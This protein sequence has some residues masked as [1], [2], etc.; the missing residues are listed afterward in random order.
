MVRRL[1]EQGMEAVLWVEPYPCRFPYWS[2]LVSAKRQEQC[3]S[4]LPSR[5]EVLHV[6]ALPLEP[7]GLGRWLNRNFLWRQ[8]W[9]RI[10]RFAAEG[11]FVLGIGR[12]CSLALAALR[13]LRPAR[14]FYDAMDNFPEFY[15]GLA[16][17]VMYRN[18]EAVAAEVDFVLASSTFLAE[19]FARRG[20]PVEK[21][22]NAGFPAEL[23]TDCYTARENTR[24]P[25]F[26]YLGCI[27][28]WFDWPLVIR[29]AKAVPWAWLDLVG[30]LAAPLPEKLPINI[31]LHPACSTAEAGEC[32]S[33]FSVGFIPFYNNTLTAGVDPIKYYDYRAAGLPVLSTSFGEMALRDQRDGVYFLD[34]S[35][36]LEATAK[37]ALTHRD[38]PREIERFRREN[39]WNIRFQQSEKLQSLFLSGA[40]RSAA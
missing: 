6:P 29:F 19:K 18:E 26:G 40:K 1:L 10:E 20:L 21:V 39:N 34:R 37:T 35:P 27:G 14:S 2:D 9:R 24:S 22:M 23:S 3:L 38:D 5:V 17:Q 31:N 32:L 30:P 8:T 15:D 16:R 13:R 4:S 7:L 33:R 36:D 12:P 25:I 28:R 11:R